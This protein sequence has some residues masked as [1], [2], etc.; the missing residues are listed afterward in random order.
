MGSPRY[1][2]SNLI[3]L[4]LNKRKAKDGNVS[5]ITRNLSKYIHDKYPITL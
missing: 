5:S 3:Y 2:K 1:G 4:L